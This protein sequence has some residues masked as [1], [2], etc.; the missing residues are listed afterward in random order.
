MWEEGLPI[1]TFIPQPPYYFPGTIPTIFFNTQRAGLNE[2]AVR[3]AIAM[4]LDYDMIGTN[5]MSGYTARLVPGLM[6]PTPAEQALVDAD[7]IRPYQWSGVDVAGANA[8]LDQAGWV[9]GADGIRA[10]G[11]VRLAFRAQCPHGWADWTAALEVVAQAGRQIGIDITTYFPEFPVW[12]ADRN[13]GTFDIIMSMAG[14]A[15][16]AA[17]W[18]R[19]FMVMGSMSL[20]PAGTP[21]TVQNWGRWVNARANEII[22]ELAAETDP[23]R[24]KALWTELNIIYL[25]EMP[26][27]GIMYRPM[28]FHTTNS[29]VWTGYPK[30]GDGSNV[31]PT[32]LMGGYGVKGLYNIRLK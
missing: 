1:E 31:P 19:A 13:N 24:V 28:V 18:S 26:A 32:L 9:R 6:L 10:K 7:A 21:N 15:G 27:A 16:A 23:A 25:Q 14:N 3:R 22:N 20:P 17:P 5:A 30:L 12:V 11:G 2:A 8:L 29:I 4:V